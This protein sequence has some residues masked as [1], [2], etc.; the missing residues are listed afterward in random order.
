MFLNSLFEYY[1][2]KDDPLN[3]KLGLLEINYTEGKVFVQEAPLRTTFNPNPLIKEPKVHSFE[4]YTYSSLYLMCVAVL[5]DLLWVL[6]LKGSFYYKEGPFNPLILGESMWKYN[7]YV[8]YA[9][10]VMLIFKVFSL[11]RRW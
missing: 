7:H 9:S 4:R 1:L 6:L 11:L 5:M 8:V 2:L 10:I 3:E